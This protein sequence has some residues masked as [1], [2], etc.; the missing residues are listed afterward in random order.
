MALPGSRNRTYATD[1]P[2]NPGDL[3]DIQ[4]CIISDKHP[5]KVMGLVG[6]AAIQ[7][8]GAAVTKN[9]TSFVTTGACVMQFNPPLHEG[10]RIKQ[11]SM[12]VAGNGVADIPQFDVYKVS[13]LGAETLLG[14]VAITNPGAGVATYTND[15]ADYTIAAGESIRITFDPNAAG[16]TV[17]N[18]LIKYDRP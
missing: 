13:A 11:V 2:V 3:N 10:D 6:M 18:A 16:I 7:I 5:D 17:Y 1:T 12:A 14:T 4:D 9:F 15:F 8:S